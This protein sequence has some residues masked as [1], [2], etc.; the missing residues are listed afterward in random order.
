MDSRR[1]LS[2]IELAHSQ[3]QT[4][5]TT[6]I[7]HKFFAAAMGL[8]AGLLAVLTF[9]TPTFA[10]P[11]LASPGGIEIVHLDHWSR[12]E[13]LILGFSILLVATVMYLALR[14]RDRRR[15]HHIAALE[16]LSEI[17]L[18]IASV[19]GED[20]RPLL[21]RLA[22]AARE[23]LGM[24]MSRVLLLCE[25]QPRLMRVVHDYGL[26]ALDSEL[27]A[28]TEYH[29][30]ESPVTDECLR[31]GKALIVTD[32]H[33]DAH[34]MNPALLDAFGVRALAMTP[35]RAGGKPI[36]VL[37]LADR[38]ARRIGESDRRLIELWGA[39]AAVS[40][41]NSRLYQHMDEA[42]RSLRHVQAQRD[43][44]YQMS[45]AVQNASTLDDALTRVAELA[46][47]G[48]GM[49]VCIVCLRSGGVGSVNGARGDPADP[50]ALRVAAITQLPYPFPLTE[51]MTLRSMF[52]PTVE[53]GGRNL[54]DHSSV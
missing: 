26:G 51:G 38:R 15:R 17:A 12:R 3:G 25:N 5:H 46:P 44:L 53:N 20:L 22:G 43:T 30:D 39:Q 36:G 27:R 2:H 31:T 29:L 14:H 34:G 7:Q 13:Q 47:T 35:L 50:E 41:V 24:P 21:D 42:I 23:L 49:D 48:L 19:P 40:I 54:I 37:L 8:A 10:A 28:R 45:T 4:L 1:T 52:R 18:A 16:R 6:R 32:S 33:R 11:P 9:A